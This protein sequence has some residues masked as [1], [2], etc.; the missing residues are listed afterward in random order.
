M[1]GDLLLCS[2][3]NKYCEIVLLQPPNGIP[4]LTLWSGLRDQMIPRAM[5]AVALLHARQVKGDDPDRKGCPSPPS[6]GLGVGLKTSSRKNMLFRDLNKRRPGLDT[7]CNA[8]AAATV[9][10][11]E[12]VDN[13]K[14][15]MSLLT[16]NCNY[17]QTAD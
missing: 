15:L 17:P 10:L 11:H 16:T 13:I 1:Y 5:Q 14:T 4:A 2:T 3:C 8:T 6:R 12:N 7:G 9:L